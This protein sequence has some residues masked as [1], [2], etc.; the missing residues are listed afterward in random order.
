[1]HGD[2]VKGC[3]ADT[4]GSPWQTGEG[5]VQGAYWRYNT[6]EGEFEG[7]FVG[8]GEG[9]GSLPHTESGG[10]GPRDREG[11]PFTPPGAAGGCYNTMA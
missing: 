8:E 9:H 10:V 3:H 7:R 2:V 6:G 4:H 1:M 5:G 11:V